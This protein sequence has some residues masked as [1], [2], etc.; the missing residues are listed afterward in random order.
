MGWDTE[1]EAPRERPFMAVQDVPPLG[2]GVR[3]PFP[4]IYWKGKPTGQPPIS[5]H[6][7]DLLLIPTNDEE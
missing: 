6:E 7:G 2:D 4:V 3:W 5:Q 1:P